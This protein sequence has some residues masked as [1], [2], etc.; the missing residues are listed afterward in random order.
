MPAKK[1]ASQSGAF[2]S[3]KVSITTLRKIKAVANEAQKR[4]TV[5]NTETTADESPSE[6][7]RT[8]NDKPCNDALGT[9]EI[10]EGILECLP[11]AKLHVIQRVN[12]RFQDV[13]VRSPRIQKKMFRR[14]DNKSGVQWKFVPPPGWYHRLTPW[15]LAQAS[16]MNNDSQELITL[17]DTNPFLS[18]SGSPD[19]QLLDRRFATITKKS[20]QRGDTLH[21]Y[22]GQASILQQIGQHNSIF[23]GL[24]SDPHCPSIEVTLHFALGKRLPTLIDVRSVVKSDTPLTIGAVIRRSLETPGEISIYWRGDGYTASGT[25]EER[26]G[27]PRHLSDELKRDF[28]LEMYFRPLGTSFRLNRTLSPTDK[29]RATVTSRQMGN[30]GSVSA[31]TTPN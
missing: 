6:H 22:D 8:Q 10:L 31:H 16:G 23:G 7:K 27:V 12:K 4:R 26:K 20:L 19:D 5:L 14:I 9:T 3:R 21:F 11:P 18:L 24:I 1:R 17:V 30:Q 15:S 29:Q 2:E 28:G 13:I 25:H